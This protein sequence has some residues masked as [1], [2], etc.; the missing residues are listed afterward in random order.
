MAKK[1]IRITNLAIRDSRLSLVEEVEAGTPS[2]ASFVS[3]RRW[4]IIHPA[5]A[6]QMI[7]MPLQPKIK[8]KTT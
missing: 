3:N 7:E 4:L 8:H 1:S 5:I 2:F 6:H